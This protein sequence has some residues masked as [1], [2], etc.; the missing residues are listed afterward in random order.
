MLGNT[1]YRVVS[2]MG[3]KIVSM[4][5]GEENKLSVG[6]RN[7]YWMIE[8]KIAPERH[9]RNKTRQ[10][11]SNCPGW[12]GR[13]FLSQP[14]PVTTFSQ[15]GCAELFRSGIGYSLSDPSEEILL[16]ARQIHPNLNWWKT[17]CCITFPSPGLHGR[18]ET[19]PFSAGCFIFGNIRWL[20]L[21]HIYL[22]LSNIQAP[23][24]MSL[25]WQLTMCLRI[26]KPSPNCLE[27]I[28]PSVCLIMIKCRPLEPLIVRSTK[29]G[30]A[31]ILEKL[32]SV[33]FKECF[34]IKTWRRGGGCWVGQSDSP[35]F[36]SQDSN[37]GLI[38]G[39]CVSI[40]KTLARDVIH[41][42]HLLSSFGILGLEGRGIW[43]ILGIIFHKS[44]NRDWFLTCKWGAENMI[45]WNLSSTLMLLQW[46]SFWRI[47]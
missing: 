25:E 29:S 13:I 42:T 12:E 23:I 1:Q 5:G 46:V 43:G 27:K 39:F 19:N 30:Q 44:R 14:N 6:L 9:R 10:A 33:C 16:S 21:L 2:I 35:L 20:G 18:S 17:F 32:S 38:I 34:T 8:A 26:F 47:V 24:F 22:M 11:T 31:S 7:Q 45:Y 3:R 4:I 15:T 40:W 28:T 41:E 37:L 36:L